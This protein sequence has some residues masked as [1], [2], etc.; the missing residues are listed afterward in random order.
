MK[1]NQGSKVLLLEL[2][3]G[4]GCLK[5][6]EIFHNPID[7]V[8]SRPLT[9]RFECYLMLDGETRRWTER[10]SFEILMNDYLGNNRLYEFMNWYE[11]FNLLDSDESIRF[12]SNIVTNKLE[13]IIIIFLSM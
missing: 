11:F 4:G 3:G 13:W 7:S 10:K 6:G 1:G 9:S 12:S 8:M 2:L 5:V